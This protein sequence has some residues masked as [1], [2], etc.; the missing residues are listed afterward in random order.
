MK[1]EKILPTILLTFPFLDFLTGICSW[2]HY[3]SIGL[4]VKGILLLL[5]LFY[6]I[7]YHKDKKTIWIFLILLCVFS[8]IYLVYQYYNQSSLFTELTHLMKIFY[9]PILIL[10]FQTYPYPLKKEDLYKVLLCYLLLYLIP[11][12]FG[13]GHNMNELYPEKNLYL[14]YF[15]TGNE[16][17]N[18]FI[19]LLAVT[20]FY[21][22][23]KKRINI[24]S[25]ILIILMLL[26]LGTKTMY[27]C[28][29]LISCYLLFQH[30]KQLKKSFTKY[31]K[32][33]LFGFAGVLI[34]F[35]LWFPRSDFYTNIKTSLRFYGVD[36]I[37]E[38]FTVQ[39]IDH[40][41]FSSRLSFLKDI[42]EIYAKEKPIGLL[43]GL[44]RAKITQTKEIE[45]DI[46]DIFYS[47]G[48][49][50]TLLYLYSLYISLRHTKWKKEYRFLFSL[51]L[52]ISC[53]T[54]HVLLSPMVS[55]FLASLIS[56][57]KE[58]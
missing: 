52:L 51:L 48:I 23:E 56:L 32:Q 11:Y 13:L 8:G 6:I 19:I 30:R 15:F 3:F 22:L 36:S 16:L 37:P 5:A 34:L 58:S 53:I 21:F 44:G 7:K 50:G 4:L 27:A 9:F 25:L 26:L 41:I 40:V 17:A 39:N 2:N 42:H 28:L 54:G 47:I 57:N 31:W 45:M 33:I 20:C 24:L 14:S 1:K 12:P 46:F 49:L 18:T 29:I 10:F 38:L 35:F 43:L 55:T